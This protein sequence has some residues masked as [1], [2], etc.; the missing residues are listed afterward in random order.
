[1]YKTHFKFPLN[2]SSL[3]SR[4]HFPE[5]FIFLHRKWY[6]GPKSAHFFVGLASVGSNA[7]VEVSSTIL[8]YSFSILNEELTLS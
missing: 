2:F 8:M 4:H 6:Y 7:P 3:Y 5:K 1:M